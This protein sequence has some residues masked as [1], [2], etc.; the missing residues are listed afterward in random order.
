[1]KPP[2]IVAA[3][4]FSP[5][6]RHA[7]DRAARI[8]HEVQAQLRLLHVMPLQPLAELR[9]WLGAGSTTERS[10]RDGAVAELN[11]LAQRLHAARQV[12]VEPVVVEGP[13]LES[14][15]QEVERARAQLL[16]L[17]I[18]GAGFMRRLVLGTTAE[19]VM[20]RAAQPVLVVR[21]TPHERYRRVLVGVDFSE[22]SAGALETARR[23]A[24]HAQL[25]LAAVF[26][27]PYEDKLRLAGVE[28]A[29]VSLYRERARSQATQRLHALAAAAGLKPGRWQPRVVEGDASFRLVELE[30]EH[31]CDLVAVGKHGTSMAVDLLLGSVTHHLLCEAQGDV[32]ISTERRAPL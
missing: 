17:G 4:D 23:F 18:R 8:A 9:S 5:H 22:W 24:P 25:V 3:T 14:T 26:R 28:E 32:L 30:Q 21:Q 27:V 10:L 29:T 1:M 16:V 7:A 6:A 20:R 19:R 11:E 12:A 15:L 13:V 31:D 2:T